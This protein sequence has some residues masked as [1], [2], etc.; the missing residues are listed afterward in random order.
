MDLN[1]LPLSEEMKKQIQ[2]AG[3]KLA[4]EEELKK[5]QA[6]VAAKKEPP[7]PEERR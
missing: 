2:E 3:R 1:D 4:I 5:Q 6:S 7:K